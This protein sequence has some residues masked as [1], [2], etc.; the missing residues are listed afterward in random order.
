M[1]FPR[2]ILVKH[3]GYVEVHCWHIWNYLE[4]LTMT[5]QQLQ[6][7]IHVITYTWIYVV[8]SPIISR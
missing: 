2:V 8:D 4:N 7:I 1:E 5:Y 6:L 3:Y